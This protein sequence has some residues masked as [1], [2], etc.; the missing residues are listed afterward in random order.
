MNAAQWAFANANQT[1]ACSWDAVINPSRTEMYSWLRLLPASFWT[2]PPA[3]WCLI[4]PCPGSRNLQ[5]NNP[6]ELLPLAV[7]VSLLVPATEKSHREDYQSNEG[8][9][10]AHSSCKCTQGWLQKH[11]W[12]FGG[13]RGL[14]QY[15]SGLT[16]QCCWPFTDG[17]DFLPPQVV[18]WN[19]NRKQSQEKKSPFTAGFLVLNLR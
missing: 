13:R 14:C 6:C 4:C 9:L 1:C 12:W 3:V 10:G 2:H 16:A 15:I 7:T 11:G 17:I 5:S 19:T 8:V 18:V